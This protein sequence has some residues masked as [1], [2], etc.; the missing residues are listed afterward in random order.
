MH[1]HFITEPQRK[2]VRRR[3]RKTALED[4]GWTVLRE[5]EVYAPGEDRDGHT[6]VWSLETAAREVGL[7][8]DLDDL[9]VFMRALRRVYVRGSHERDQAYHEDLYTRARAA[10]GEAFVPPTRIARP[11]EAPPASEPTQR[12][13]SPEGLVSYP[14]VEAHVTKRAQYSQEAKEKQ[15]LRPESELV[16][17]FK[18]YLEEIGHAT[19]GVVV[20]VG[21]EV[22][23]ADL[24]DR[25]CGVLY[26]AKA[27][28]DRQLI[29]T[30]IGQLLDYRRFI[31][32][33]PELRV[34]LPARP[35]QDLCAL[36]AATGIGATWRDRAGWSD[37]APAALITPG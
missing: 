22:I 28:P 8:T 4:L 1:E 18:E 36:L 11:A 20:P 6:D 9:Y 12:V 14:P 15:L 29:R 32:P 26:E 3:Y 34:L 17:Q 16:L 7:P 10:L 37:A 21:T 31:K 19:S 5:H 23:R 2:R 30:A 33:E 27:S 35:N 25:T 24:F 13:I